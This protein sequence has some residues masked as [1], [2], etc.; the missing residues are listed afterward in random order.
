MPQSGRRISAHWLKQII[1]FEILFF[2]I[3]IINLPFA[4]HSFYEYTL[5]NLF[6]TFLVLCDYFRF[7]EPN[8]GLHFSPVR[9]IHHCFVKRTFRGCI[10]YWNFCTN[11]LHK[12][13][14]FDVTPGNKTPHPAVSAHDP[15]VS[16]ALFITI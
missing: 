3:N 8:I 7:E 2:D 1:N 13:R 10:F 6:V 11:K 5:I 15:Q 4:L 12:V 9:N 16:V 14:N